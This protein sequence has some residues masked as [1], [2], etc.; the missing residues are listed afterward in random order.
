MV[1]AGAANW[2][3][4]NGTGPFMLS[5]FVSGNSNTYVRNPIYWDKEKIGGQE[6]KI[7]FVDKLVYRTIK[8]RGAQ[9]A[10]LRTAKIDLLETINARYVPD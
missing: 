4:V 8:G 6:Y 1:E 9:H 5:D 3:N 7:P 10:A 2:K